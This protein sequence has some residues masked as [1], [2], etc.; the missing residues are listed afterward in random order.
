MESLGYVLIYFLKGKLPWQG[1]KTK[2]KDKKYEL[3]S[4]K[5]TVTSSET[6]CEGLPQEFKKYIDYCKLLKFDEAP[7]YNMLRGMFKNLFIKNEFKMD[8][9]YDWK[10]KKK[11]NDENSDFKPN[12]SENETNKSEIEIKSDGIDNLSEIKMTETKSNDKMDIE[13]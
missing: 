8:F 1:L 7:N 3:I 11:F 9:E 2:D 10:I 12:K 13:N 4:E 5:K 6:L